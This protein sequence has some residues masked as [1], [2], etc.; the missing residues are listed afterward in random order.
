ME[1]RI[2]QKPAILALEIKD[3]KTEIHHKPADFSLQTAAAS[4]EMQRSSDKVN[5]SYIP[6]EEA[7]GYYR[8]DAY[9]RKMAADG[10][11]AVAV[12]IDR[13]VS[14][15]NQMLDV[16]KNGFIIPDLAQR[17][18]QSPM[19][20]ISIGVK[21]G[22]DVSYDPGKLKIDAKPNPVNYSM[23]TGELNVEATLGSVNAYLKQEPSFDIEFIGNIF[24]LYR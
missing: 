6:C 13:W 5:I 4:F 10:K 3:P 2:H 9:G 15:G 24:D 7:I 22:A 23:K 1:L 14:E 12:G 17:D 11:A 20:E 16:H 18:S 19:R 21:P 8:Y